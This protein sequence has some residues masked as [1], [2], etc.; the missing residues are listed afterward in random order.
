MSV[1]AKA[2]VTIEIDV[3]SN[4]NDATTVAQVKK[5]AIDDAKGVIRRLH[6]DDSYR[7]KV[8]GEPDITVITFDV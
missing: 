2:T 3:N 8:I 7:I 4:W 6:G 1:K 5:Q